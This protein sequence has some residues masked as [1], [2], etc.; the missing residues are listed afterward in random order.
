[1]DALAQEWFTNTIPTTNILSVVTNNG[2]VITNYVT[3]TN[4]T[5]GNVIIGGNFLR[6][7]GGSTRGDTRPRSNV[8]RLIGGATPGPGNIQFSYSSYTVD[9]N[10]GTL[11]VSLTRSSTNNVNLGII[12]NLGAVCSQHS[13]PTWRRRGRASPA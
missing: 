6:V 7:G 10:A 11:F 9:K 4:V 5:G 2:V 1:M 13:P 3:L 8:A 12:N